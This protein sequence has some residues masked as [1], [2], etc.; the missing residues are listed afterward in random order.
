MVSV[1]IPNFNHAKFLETRI[2]SVFNQTYTDFEVIILD[3]CSTDNSLAVIEKYRNHPNVARVLINEKN[4]GSTFQ[5][6][7]NG[8]RLAKGE[9][10]WIAESDDSCDPR[11]LEE[12][13]SR[14]ADTELSL[15]FSN[16]VWIDGDG[17]VKGGYDSGFGKREDAVLAGNALIQDFLC[18]R[19]IIPNASAVVFKKEGATEPMLRKLV[20]YK[21]NGDWYL[22]ISLLHDKTCAF[23]AEPLNH[24]RRHEGAGS[25]ANIE[26]FKNIEETFLLNR[27]LREYQFKIQGRYW[28]KAWIS[29]A[30]YRLSVL[31]RSNFVPIYKKAFTLFPFPLLYILMLTLAKKVQRIFSV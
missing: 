8:I 20:E 27:V 10:I 7:V 5:Q 26:N 11:F 3:D 1:I 31:F 9:Y 18:L 14:L 19:N 23:I 13:M 22:W 28:L 24:F 30:D 29:Q 2:Q 6:W 25:R 16:S 12:S 15:C 4:G 17:V 21:I